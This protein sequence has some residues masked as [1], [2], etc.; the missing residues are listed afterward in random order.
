MIC[1]TSEGEKKKRPGS[2]FM[3]QVTGSTRSAPKRHRILSHRFAAPWQV[4]VRSSSQSM[5]D[6]RRMY[7]LGCMRLCDRAYRRLA[8]AGLLSA[9][10]L[11]KQSCQNSDDV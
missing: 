8:V 6:T 11:L 5:Q 4:R 3:S 10:R 9:F 2:A 7:F 1:G